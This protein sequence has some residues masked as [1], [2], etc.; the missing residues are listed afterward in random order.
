MHEILFKGLYSQLKNT[1]QERAGVKELFHKHHR[2]SAEAAPDILTHIKNKTAHS[3]QAVE[4][5][6][7]FCKTNAPREQNMLHRMGSD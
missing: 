4:V 1:Q 7:I 3:V 6:A 2:L 5:S